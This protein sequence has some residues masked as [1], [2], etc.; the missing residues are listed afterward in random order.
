MNKVEKL[1]ELSK[2]YET[3]YGRDGVHALAGALSAIIT[4]EQL[5]LLIKVKQLQIK[6]EGSK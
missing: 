1:H 5:D 3:I 2:H 4:D 6:I